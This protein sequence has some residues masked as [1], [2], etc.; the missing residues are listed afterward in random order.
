MNQ[1]LFK[2][3]NLLLLVC[4]FMGLHVHAASGK[5]A[6]SVP[7]DVSFLV[8]DLKY[9]DKEGVK[10]CEIQQASVS[11]FLG[12]RCIHGGESP[13]A[14]S[15]VAYLS[16]WGKQGWFLERQLVEKK[17]GSALKKMDWRPLS[18]S[19][20]I[21]EDPAFLSLQPLPVFDPESI[22][23]YHAFYY[24][25]KLSAADR[26]KLEQTCPG[27]IIIDR[28]SYP[29]WKDKHTV[30]ALFYDDPRLL[31]YRPVSKLYSKEPRKGLAAQVKREIPGEIVVIKP[32]GAF[33]GNGVIVV[34]KVDLDKT[35]GWIVKKSGKLKSHPDY[36]YRY[37]YK[38]TSNSFTV[39]EFIP[40]DPLAVPRLGNALYDPT[41]RVAFVA[42]LDK[43][44]V[45]IHFCGC[46]WKFPL[47]ALS[48]EGTL[49][50][51]YKSYGEMPYYMEVS[52]A[53][54]EKVKNHLVQALPLMYEKMLRQ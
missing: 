37:W 49:N 52:A 11:Q 44:A 40:S 51:K 23:D 27:V 32:R 43:G 42:T 13:I 7:V 21:Y 39:E 17:I 20:A 45:S 4:C 8:A 14:E 10:I 34:P 25:K 53:E 19:Q 9:S 2:N 38:D 1:R 54:W 18:N 50:E 15:F 30:N 29:F 31:P 3:L 46:F 24:G 26:E 6:F 33:L 41:M 47:K 28:A 12:D 48:E 16:S 5:A 22:A 35:L 36:A